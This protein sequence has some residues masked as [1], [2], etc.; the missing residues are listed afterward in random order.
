VPTRQ[1]HLAMRTSWWL[2]VK[3]ASVY[4]GY[5]GT[6]AGIIVLAL[7]LLRYVEPYAVTKA[8]K[9]LVTGAA[10]SVAAI[11]YLVLADIDL[12]IVTP[13]AIGM[14]ISGALGP[15]VVRRF[16]ERLLR[17]SVG[18]PGCSSCGLFST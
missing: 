14:F 9:T 6:G 3:A 5:L 7:L 4:A 10:N 15:A 2:A 17:Y 11:L 1:R 13:M 18:A 16:P 12:M 8:I